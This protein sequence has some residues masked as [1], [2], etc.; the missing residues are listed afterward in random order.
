MGERFTEAVELF[1]KGYNLE[2][3]AAVEAENA[4]DTIENNNMIGEDL[5]TL[6]EIEHYIINH[7]LKA[8]A[9]DIC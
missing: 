5:K 8:L 1:L 4:I 6:E 9:Y 3:A 2:N 7:I